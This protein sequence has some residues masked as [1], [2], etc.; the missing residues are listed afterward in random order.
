MTRFI[1]D[2]KN[3]IYSAY[4][5]FNEH[6][7]CSANT[8]P[9]TCCWCHASCLWWMHWSVR[10]CQGTTPTAQHMSNVLYLSISAPPPPPPL[11]PRLSFV[12]YQ[13]PPRLRAEDSSSHQEQ[14][15]PHHQETST[16][17]RLQRRRNRSGL[18][19][20]GVSIHTGT[21][22]TTWINRKKMNK[23]ME[24]LIQKWMNE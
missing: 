18:S 21:T 12:L 14:T 6:P 8:Q 3:K 5:D 4:Y 23:W 11:C 7:F 10:W 22:H 19:G 2:K 20:G 13:H 1:F 16:F 15:P 24:K 17:R 9:L